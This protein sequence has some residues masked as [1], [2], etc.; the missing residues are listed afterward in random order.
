[1]NE[2]EAVDLVV[3]FA[4]TIVVNKAEVLKVVRDLEST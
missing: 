3:S 4:A 1:M 2:E